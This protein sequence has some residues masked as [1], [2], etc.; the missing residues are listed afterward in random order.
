LHAIPPDVG[1]GV[2]DDE[3]VKNLPADQH[4]V[5]PKKSERASLTAFAAEA[6]AEASS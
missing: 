2:V 6:A 1:S 3:I 5:Q 4:R